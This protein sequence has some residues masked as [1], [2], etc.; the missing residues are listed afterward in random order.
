LIVQKHDVTEWL[1]RFLDTAQYGTL[2]RAA[3][4][5]N[6]GFDDELFDPTYTQDDLNSLL[7]DATGLVSALNAH[8]ACYPLGYPTTLLFDENGDPL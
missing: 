3:A 6:L 4:L 2:N 1:S 7:R 8:V 5:A